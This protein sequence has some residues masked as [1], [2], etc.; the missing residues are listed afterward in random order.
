MT[1]EEAK[2]IF[3]NRV[4]IEVP[5]GTYYDAD[6]WRNAVAIISKYLEQQ[7]CEDTEIKKI[8]EWEIKG[9]NAELWIVKG[10]LQ[11]R[12]LGTIHNIPLQS[13]NSQEPKTGHWIVDWSATSRLNK[14]RSLTYQYHVHCD[15]C[16]Y[17]WDYTTDKKDSLV[18]NFCPNCGVKMV[19]LQKNM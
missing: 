11:I 1:F 3:L 9:K 12:Y 5:G 10:N 14:D 17:R 19:E 8:D 18:S 2:K 15:K 13:I 7:P 4:Y 6:K 16:G